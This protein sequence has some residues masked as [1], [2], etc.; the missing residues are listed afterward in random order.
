MIFSSVAPLKTVP[1]IGD[2]VLLIL[3]K[4]FTWKSHTLL[5]SEGRG[6]YLTAWVLQQEAVLLLGGEGGCLE[7]TSRSTLWVS[8]QPHT[9]H[10]PHAK[11][12]IRTLRTF[13]FFQSEDEWLLKYIEVLVLWALH[14]CRAYS[15]KCF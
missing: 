9:N 14:K 5:V 3:K 7:C 12:C 11:Y 6:A 4:V 1:S 10:V 15:R 13:T 2:E 8:C